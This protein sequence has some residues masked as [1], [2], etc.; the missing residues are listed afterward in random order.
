M[1]AFNDFLLLYTQQRRRTGVVMQGGAYDIEG[2]CSLSG[3]LA[4]Y[5]FS[6]IQFKAEEDSVLQLIVY[7]DVEQ[8]RVR[9]FQQQNFSHGKYHVTPKAWYSQ[10]AGL[11]ER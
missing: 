1:S 7:S 9:F 5:K 11:P 3:E 8:A 10:A 6:D 4:T 2:V